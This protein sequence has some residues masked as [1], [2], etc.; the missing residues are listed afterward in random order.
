MKPDHAQVAAIVQPV[1]KNNYLLNENRHGLMTPASTQKLLTA[2]A[3]YQ[4]LGRNYRFDTKLVAQTTANPQHLA[5]LQIQFSGDPGLTTTDL[6][7]LIRALQKQGVRRI[8]SLS[9]YS[10]QSSQYHAPGWVWD[11]LGICFAAPISGYILDRNCISAQL[12][13]F[14]NETRVSHPSFLPISV[15]TDASY[16]AQPHDFCDLHIESFPGNRFNVIGCLTQRNRLNLEIALSDPRDFV[17]Q[18]IE[19]LLKDAGISL[20]TPISYSKQASYGRVLAQHQ[21]APLHELMV[22]MLTDSDNLIADTTFKQMGSHYFAHQ[23]SFTSGSVAVIQ[24]LTGL[25]IDMSDAV[26]VDGSGLSRYNLISAQQLLQTLQLIQANPKFTE[27]T[28]ALAIAGESGTLRRKTGFGQAP[29]KQRVVAKTGTMRGVNGLAGYTLN[30]EGK[31]AY[32]FV[33]L[34]NGGKLEVSSEP[35]LLKA[36]INQTD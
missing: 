1:G 27:L 22:T 23:G 2:V 14:G 17:N 13:S 16:Q 33:Y 31:P 12:T 24:T 10:S 30:T 32:A 8:D 35:I 26:I 3:A 20:S 15:S 19:R 4:I 5:N 28:Q 34:Q 25:G 7:A 29:L 6:R 9:L 21:S 11:D 18:T 36:L